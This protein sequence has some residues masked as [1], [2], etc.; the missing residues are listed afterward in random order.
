MG[1]RI[2]GD[3]TA[4]DFNAFL[5]KGVVTYNFTDDFSLSASVQRAY[6][7]GGLSFNGFRAALPIPGGG[8]ADDQ[9]VL[10]AAGIVNSFEPEFTT[11]Y[12]LALRSQWFDRRLTVNANTFYIKYSDQQINIQLSSNPLDTLT[13]NVGESRLV[14]FELET[15]AQPTERLNLFANVGFSDTEFTDGSDVVGSADLTGFEFPFAPT[16]T[17]G[18]GARYVH[19]TGLFGNARFRYT[20]DSFGNAENDSTGVNDQFVT[21]DLT[22]GFQNELFLAEV[23]V[24]NLFDD[25]YLTFNPNDPSFGGV[26]SA[27][28]PR[29]VGGRILANF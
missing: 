9:A 26:A 20:G 1:L 28:D 21:I 25:E 5:P 7:A 2:A 16:W 19:P 4:N 17:A 14:G 29:V 15:F 24:T 6:R 8:S 22:A 27:G 3:F 10:E 11:N 23:F 12:E 13:D 18:A